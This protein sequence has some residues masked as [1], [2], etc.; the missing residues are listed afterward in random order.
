MQKQRRNFL[1]TLLWGLGGGLQSCARWWEDKE[2]VA[3]NLKDL[4]QDKF[5]TLEFNGNKIIIFF[6][7]GKPYAL[8]LVCTHKK[9]TVRFRP[10][11]SQFVCPC[12]KGRYDINGKV[13]SGKPPKP[14]KRF[15]TII[16]EKQVVVINK[17]IS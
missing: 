6:N 11:E 17:E 10:P 4:A 3:G 12:H 13:L 7:E 5:W 14:L 15:E 9:C 2:L 16:R 1:R 8:S